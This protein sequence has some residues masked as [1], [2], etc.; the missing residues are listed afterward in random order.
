MKFSIYVHLVEKK[1]KQANLSK[2]YDLLLD[3]KQRVKDDGESV[4]AIKPLAWVGEDLG[5]TIFDPLISVEKPDHEILQQYEGIRK[6]ARKLIDQH[7]GENP[8]CQEFLY[9]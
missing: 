3:R 8:L 1:H 5:P 2:L 7:K 9:V 4:L 6:K